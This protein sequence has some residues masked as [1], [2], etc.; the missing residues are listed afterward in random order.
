MMVKKSPQSK[1]FAIG[2]R[3]V[4]DNKQTR[5]FFSGRIHILSVIIFI[6][7]GAVVFRLYFLQVEAH[8]TYKLLSEDQH[9][10]YKKLVP[11]RG[12]I[13]AQDKSGPYPLS[14]NKDTKMAYAVPKEIADPQEAA[15]KI[16]QALGMEKGPLLEK[17]N[18]PEDMYEVIKHRLSDEEIDRINELK[19]PGIHL[20]EES[21][22]YYPGGNLASQI[23]GFVGWKGDQYGGRYGAEAYFEDKLKGKEGE[24]SQN[25]DTL[26]R[27]I[28]IGEKQLE[29]ASDGE[30]I[31]LTIDHIVQYET[32]K[33]LEKSVERFGAKS[34]SI[35]V[36]EPTTGKILAMANWPSFNPNDYSQVEDMDVYRNL[37][38]SDTYEPGSIFKPITMASAI[39]SGKVGPETTY[40]DTGVVKEAGY[41]IKNSDEKS[42]GRQTM[43]QVLEKSL[44]TGVIFAE[45]QLGNKNFADYVRRFGFGEPTGLTFPGEAGGNIENLKY[46]NRNIEFFTAAFGQGITVTPLQILS[47]YNVIANGGLL[48]QPQL[49]EKYILPDGQEQAVEP[50]EVKRV[51]SQK[52]AYETSGMLRSVVEK[53][54]GKRAGIPGYQVA[55]KTGTAQVASTEKKGYEEGKTIGSFAGFAPVDNP[56][57]SIIVKINDPTAVEWAESSAAP[58]FGELMKFLLDYYNVEPTE[59]YSQKDLDIFFATHNLRKVVEEGEEANKPDETQGVIDSSSSVKKDSNKDKKKKDD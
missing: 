41:T 1:K 55:G 26:G 20:A 13:F 36:M 31:V 54:H 6:I 8:D 50:V 57:F 4:L 46:L 27:W 25:S 34:G 5:L 44:N 24:V 11:R 39:D 29:P 42:N 52:A 35:I 15:E 23:V 49:V 59:E 19:L 51:I 10:L 2:S 37:A 40:S 17:F 12:E 33:I 30:G 58:T 38:V 21:Y 22:R 43:T 47:A 7:F 3:C 16:G 48:M 14:V 32:E 53:G 18:R 28:S 9:F 56:R 45:K